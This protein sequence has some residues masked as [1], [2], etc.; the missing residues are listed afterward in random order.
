MEEKLKKLF[1]VDFFYL[2]FSIGMI[3]MV[4]SGKNILD[5]GYYI[6]ITFCYIKLKLYNK[7]I[8]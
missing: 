8:I 4:V 2:L 1:T 3:P 5:L 6:I 7:K